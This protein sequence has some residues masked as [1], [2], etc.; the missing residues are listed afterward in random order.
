MVATVQTLK[1]SEKIAIFSL[2]GIGA[3]ASPVI[4]IDASTLFGAKGGQVGF[5]VGSERLRIS[6]VTW[7][8]AGGSVQ[9]TWDATVDVTA[10][11]LSGDGSTERGISIPNNAGAGSVGGLN[12]QTIGFGATSTYNI[13]IEVT[14]TTSYTLYTYP[15]S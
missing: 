1:D 9:L 7:S 15:S 2:T 13:I 12:L 4:K 8:I 6:H 10:M 11:V 5:A 3:E 14:K